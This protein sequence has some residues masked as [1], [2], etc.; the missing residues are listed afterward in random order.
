MQETIINFV[1]DK[2]FT[3]VV[4]YFFKV[5]MNVKIYQMLTENLLQKLFC[6]T[7]IAEVTKL[8]SKEML[9]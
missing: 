7:E 5:N 2:L 6:G 1:L 3:F 9:V 8:I 4:G